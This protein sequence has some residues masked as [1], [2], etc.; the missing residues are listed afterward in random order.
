MNENHLVIAII[1]ISV[2]L[3]ITLIFFIAREIISKNTKA[4]VFPESE[5]Q[6][7][8]DKPANKPESE[9]ETRKEHELEP[10]TTEPLYS[11]EDDIVIIDEHG[12]VLTEASQANER[13]SLAPADT[14]E[15]L[16]QDSMLR[17]HAITRLYAIVESNMPLRPTDS[18]L[19]RHYDTMINH[20]LNKLLGEE[21]V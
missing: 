9:T 3:I 15:N 20:E 4:I 12:I 6:P 2:L 5:I 13:V 11:A 7:T 8:V 1:V 10:P 21:V 14:C 17:R 16:P 19:R 18:A